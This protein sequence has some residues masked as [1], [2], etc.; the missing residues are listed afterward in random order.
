M[1]GDLEPSEAVP[2][3]GGGRWPST[4]R[5]VLALVVVV[6][7]GSS[8]GWAVSS[9]QQSER[10]PTIAVHSPVLTTLSWFQAVNA[11]DM[12][13]AVAHFVPAD[14]GMMEWSSWGPP[15]T[16][17]HCSARSVTTSKA[18]VYCTFANIDYPATGMSNVSFWDVSLTRES[19]GPW[20]IDHYGQG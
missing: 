7:T 8:I 20:L 5:W 9:S 19:S 17:I 6:V 12:A 11:H 2:R 1:S 4:L 14:R 18:S 16:H 13:L 3:R 10:S 15:F